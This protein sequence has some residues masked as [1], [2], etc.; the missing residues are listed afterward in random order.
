LLLIERG[1]AVPDIQELQQTLQLTF[2]QPELLKQALV[3]S[4][5]INENPSC[6]IGHNERL[7]FFGD[8]VL[9]FIVAEKLYRDFPQISEGE[10]TRLRAALVRRETLAR[11][12]G[13]I[14]LGSYLLMGKGEEAT[15]GRSKAPN[16]AG[17][18]EALIAAVY[19]DLGAAAAGEMIHRLYAE[20]WTKSTDR[21]NMLDTK[22]RLQEIVQSRYQE[23][24]VYCLISETGPDHEKQFMVEVLVNDKMMGSGTGKSKKLAETEAA[25]L[26]LKH[27]TDLP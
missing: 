23:T 26:A 8:A 13:D 22:S 10:M 25:R 4:S 1:Q 20:E 19:L 16:L 21:A 18:L 2:R 27:L 7:E 12:A 5:Y 6:Q 14:H 3:H 9:D 11:I 24:P 15:G 17:A